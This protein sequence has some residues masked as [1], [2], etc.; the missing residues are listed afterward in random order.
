MAIGDFIS[1]TDYNTIRTKIFNVM[2]TGSGNFGYGQT[3]FS[4]LVAA[5]NS[6]TKT[7]WDALRYDIYN[8]LLHQTGSAAAL[9]TVSVGDVVRYGASQPNFQYNT[10]AD[11]ATT[12]RFDLGTG[13]FVTEAIDSKTYSSSWINSL[14]ATATVTFS[15]AEQARFFFNAGGKIRFASSRTGGASV[16]QNTSWS[17]LLSSAGTQTFVGG[18]SGVNFFSLTNSYQTFYTASGSS[19][20]S[21]NQW[22]L[23][24]LCNVSSNTTGTANSITFRVTWI[25]NYTDPPVGG[26]FTPGDFPPGD[27]VDGTLTLTVD[28]VRPSGFLQPSG[29]FTIISPNSSVVSAI[30]GS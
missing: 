24:A 9:T 20:Y 2:A 23:E 4:S 22:R 30:S 29:T 15:T 10:F 21:A 28:Q 13:Q 16:A 3:T 19:A 6:V 26:G 7:Q 18:P 8:A 25:D 11:T 5:G 14:T 1:A 27:L 12:N 17:N